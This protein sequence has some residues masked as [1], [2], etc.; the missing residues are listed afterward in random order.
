MIRPVFGA[1]LEVSQKFINTIIPNGVDIEL[2][3]QLEHD[4]DNLKK[5][6]EAHPEVEGGGRYGDGHSIKLYLNTQ[7]P[8]DDQSLYA[9]LYEYL[10]QASS[11]SFDDEL[12]TF[13]DKLVAK[14]KRKGQKRNEYLAS[15][16][17]AN[18]MKVL[19]TKMMPKI[20]GLWNEIDRQ[21]SPKNDYPDN[22]DF[23]D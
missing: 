17:Y 4:L 12:V 20:H 5:E 19:N 9:T 10:D 23:V 8:S 18:F 7:G 2:H 1:K 6:L 3:Q 13:W 11:Q 21:N 15:A 22:S 16:R 14:F